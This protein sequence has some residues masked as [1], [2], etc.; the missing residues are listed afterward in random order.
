VAFVNCGEGWIRL[1]QLRW[2]TEEQNARKAARYAGAL[3]SM[4]GG[5][6]SP[7]SGT[8]VEC[9][10]MTPQPGLGRPD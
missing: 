10:R 2:D 8:A 3:L 6:F 4:L 5:D 7:R 1:D 9:A